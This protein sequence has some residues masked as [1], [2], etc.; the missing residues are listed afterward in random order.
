MAKVITNARIID[1]RSD[2]KLGYLRFD[3]RI[4]AAGK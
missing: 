3:D 4:I 2:I 1:G